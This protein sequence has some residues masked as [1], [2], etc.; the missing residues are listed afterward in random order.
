[1]SLEEISYLEAWFQSIPRPLPDPIPYRQGETIF[2]PEGFLK[3]HFTFL[4]A[5]VD[6]PV[7]YDPGMLRVKLLKEYLIKN[8]HAKEQGQ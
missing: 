1:M 5:N 6:K 3:K 8:G 7:L 2:E 4:K